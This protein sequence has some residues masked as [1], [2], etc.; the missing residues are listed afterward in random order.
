M[1]TTLSENT[2]TREQKAQ[3]FLAREDSTKPSAGVT[4]AEDAPDFGANELNEINR[5][6]NKVDMWCWGRHR[7]QGGQLCG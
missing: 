2:Q 3:K 7:E 1:A 4:I 5:D 6:I